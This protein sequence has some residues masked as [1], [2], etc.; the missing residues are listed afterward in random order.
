MSIWVTCRRIFVYHAWNE[1]PSFL[2]KQFLNVRFS[3]C[4]GISY[5][6]KDWYAVAEQSR[7]V[8]SSCVRSVCCCVMCANKA[9]VKLRACIILSGFKQTHFNMGSWSISI[10]EKSSQNY[11]FK[12]I[13]YLIIYSLY[14][15]MLFS[16]CYILYS[17]YEYISL[18]SHYYAKGKLFFFSSRKHAHQLQMARFL[19]WG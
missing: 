13:N 5:G 3:H 4:F 10:N 6:L 14:E 9:G 17:L 16:L 7:L 18:Y 12:E 15:Y 19:V 2:F 8:F 11:F 1:T